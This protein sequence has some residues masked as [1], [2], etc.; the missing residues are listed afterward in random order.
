MH[1]LICRFHLVLR[2][3]KCGLDIRGLLCLKHLQFIVL[4]IQEIL[5]PSYAFGMLDV[6]ADIGFSFR[7]GPILSR[8]NATPGQG[9]TG[10]PNTLIDTACEPS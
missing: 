5:E 3:M 2:R 4:F 1:P 8:K 9:L 10:E 6:D 7:Y